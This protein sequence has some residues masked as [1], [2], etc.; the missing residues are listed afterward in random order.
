MLDILTPPYEDLQKRHCTYYQEEDVHVILPPGASHEPA[1]DPVVMLVSTIPDESFGM[2]R[3]EYRGL[4]VC[5]RFASQALS[6]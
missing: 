3:G 6:Q 5:F 4:P 2:D 1:M